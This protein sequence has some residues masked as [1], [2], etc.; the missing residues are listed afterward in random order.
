MT[1]PI[2]TYSPRSYS[3][4]K[5]SNDE[6]SKLFEIDEMIEMIEMIEKIKNGLRNDEMKKSE[7][8]PDKQI[9]GAKYQSMQFIQTSQNSDGQ[10]ISKQQPQKEDIRLLVQRCKTLETIMKKFSI[11]LDTIENKN[12]LNSINMNINNVKQ[13]AQNKLEGLDFITSIYYTSLE[14][15]TIRFIVIYDSKDILKSEKQLRHKFMEIENEFSD[16]IIEHIFL[17]KDEYVSEHTIGTNKL[18]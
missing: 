14:N 16:I 4:H 8:Y 1:K 5:V 13:F 17:H 12:T 11:R 15:N 2:T 10:E 6:N 9:S 18:Q 3:R 7:D